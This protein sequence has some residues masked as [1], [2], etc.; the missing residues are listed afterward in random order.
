MK[1]RRESELI[2]AS[3]AEQNF[4]SYFDEEENRFI[5]ARPFR[6]G[7]R[8]ED[9]DYSPLRSTEVFDRYYEK[10]HTYNPSYPI[11]SCFK[12]IVDTIES[13]QVTV[14][15]GATG[16]GKTTQVPQFILDTYAKDRKHCNII[17]TQPRRIAATSIASFICKERGW[18]L[19]N[20]VGYQ[21]GLN[22]CLTE[23]TRLTFV[24]TGVL[25]Q[26]LIQMK[27]M[28]QF[29]HV[30]LDE[31]HERDQDTDFCLLVVRKLLRTNSPHVKVVLMSAS[32]DTHVFRNYFSASV[33]GFVEPAPVVTIPGKI[34][35]VQLRYLNDLRCS[36]LGNVPVPEMSEPRINQDMYELCARLI[37]DFDRQESDME[38]RMR[39]PRSV[40]SLGSR[41][42]VLVFL[43]GLP[44][45]KE[46]DRIL[47][48]TLQEAHLTVLPLHSSVT[49]EEQQRVFRTHEKG[50][51][52]VILATNIA[53][54]S[55]TVP[56]IK[57]VI[58][59]CLCK[60]LICDHETNYQ[61]LTTT[62]A[63][64][65]SLKQR[66][67]R[68]GRVAAGVC[69]RFLTMEA[70]DTH[71]NNFSTPELQRC[72]LETSILR[73]KLLGMGEPRRILGSAL[74]PPNLSNIERT[75][76]NL[77]EVGALS[78]YCG[79]AIS[80]YD[81]DLTFVGQVLAR[82]PIDVKIGRLL[83]LGHVFRCL[84]EMLV[85]G[86]ALS[87][88]SIFT[89]YYHSQ[90]L[91]YKSK[92]SW[93]ENTHSDCI[94]VLTAYTQWYRMKITGQFR[95]KKD[96]QHWCSRN[97]IQIKAISEVQQL[98]KEME[99][100]LSEFN[101]KPTHQLI[102]NKSDGE[103]SSEDLLILKLVL[104][105]GFY[106]NYFLLAPFDEDAARKE[107]S[108]K[109]PLSTVI[110][111][112]L[113]AN[114][115]QYRGAICQILEQNEVKR[116][117]AL[118]FQSSKMYVEF[119]RPVPDRGQSMKERVQSHNVLP[120]V[121]ASL[122]LRH[123][124]IP[125]SLYTCERS[126]HVEQPRMD[127]RPPLREEHVLNDFKPQQLP[128]IGVIN[129]VITEIVDPAHFWGQRVDISEMDQLN[130]LMHRINMGQ[131][132]LQP[133]PVPPEDLVG[134]CCLAPYSQTGQ[135]Y[136][137]KVTS[138]M[139]HSSIAAVNF[140]D[141]GNDELVAID[142]LREVP[143]EAMAYPKQ[144]IEFCLIGIRPS[145]KMSSDGQWTR[146]AISRF[147]EL[148]ANKVLVANIFSLVDEQL[149]IALYD[150]SDYCYVMI[151]DALRTEGF[152]DP[153]VVE[154]SYVSRKA[155]AVAEQEE[156]S[157]VSGQSSSTTS[158]GV[159]NLEDI[160]GI[161]Q[162]EWSTADQ[163]FTQ[164]QKTGRYPS[165]MGAVTKVALKGPFHPYE[166]SFLPL[167]TVGRRK[168]AHI[169]RHSVNSVTIDSETGIK[170]DRLM[171]ATHVAVS[172][173][174]NAILARE[175]TLLPSLR[176]LPALMCLLFCPVAELRTNKVH[177]LY[178]GALCGLGCDPATGE[179]LYQQH[180]VEISFD[181]AITDQDINKV[182]HLRNAVNVALADNEGTVFSGQAIQK[183]QSQARCLILDL[184]HHHREII[185]PQPYDRV[186]QWNQ[187]PSHCLVYPTQRGIG[188]E[189]DPTNVPFLPL[190]PAIALISGNAQKTAIPP[191][192]KQQRDNLTELYR[193]ADSEEEVIDVTCSLCHLKFGSRRTLV[194]HLRSKP[195]QYEERLVMDKLEGH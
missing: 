15:E 60:E 61:C 129:V 11:T 99:G 48:K 132:A 8:P 106:P 3:E 33:N 135:L 137:A 1:Q 6:D 146:Q 138:V 37:R 2:E 17:C 87:L 64:K 7:A 164:P 93:S 144:A 74:Q 148:T 160:V 191:K 151:N 94:A 163:P 13:S 170:H 194:Q 147:L 161:A 176:G 193:L 172:A 190:H 78:V 140:V 182:N 124:R 186:C 67:G 113:P 180:D 77:K 54:S 184:V 134:Q 58:D 141:F 103:Y 56:D 82:L 63:S 125:L 21:I 53:E 165:S 169:D 142:A 145:L 18:Q 105:G 96:E 183:L 121:Y 86:A 116:G 51:R 36:K 49:L 101:I 192:L 112:G 114:P 46:M 12:S 157:K 118:F 79:D 175:T 139:I 41:G 178:T 92:V 122:K 44:E 57:Y 25:L 89:T 59:F 152:A 115:A 47:E 173:S 130:A 91:S 111:T 187:V 123:L 166:V 40:S 52:K 34:Y 167:T 69:Y 153:E 68:A 76:L 70:Y 150:T 88:K 100:R 55:I 9:D 179:P 195:H 131:S 24:T 154:E 162:V 156:K 171:V 117:K 28:N 75:I 133:L 120:D 119:A 84:P 168:K 149:R 19:G 43:P 109:D 14:I 185:S 189:D 23:D 30:I 50:R 39:G 128:K 81:G 136:R 42:A 155:R 73:S 83:L 90:I 35:E 29:S 10:P 45:I 177:E 127:V 66:K 181:V 22:R 32:I 71:L 174:G 80:P 16:S 104:C 108:G 102:R 126:E 4:V 143:G 31:V 72:P 38:V 159:K 110:L 5:K 20:L 26:K 95:D 188:V 27:N 97:M 85:I 158:K 98:V 107:M 62:W 65:A